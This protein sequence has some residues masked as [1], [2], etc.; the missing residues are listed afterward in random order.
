MVPLREG[1]VA[2]SGDYERYVMH[3]GRRYHHIIDP[4]TGR[5]TRGI[6][7]VTLVAARV[8]EVNGIG[9]AAMVAG[10]QRVT[11]L[12]DRCGIDQALVVRADGDAWI[13][14]ALASRLGPAT[15]SLRGDTR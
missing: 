3:E 11:A 2:S 13:S 4:A 14:P 12:L 15:V 9:A 8:E 1:I 7:G 10:P 5:P 6:H